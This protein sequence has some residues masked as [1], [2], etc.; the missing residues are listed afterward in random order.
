MNSHGNTVL[1]Q[2]PI[3]SYREKRGSKAGTVTMSGAHAAG[4]TSLTV[5][6]GTGTFSR[7]DWIQIARS[8]T[9]PIAHVVTATEVAGVVPIYP[10]LRIAKS[11]GDTVRHLGDGTI[12]DTMELA[13]D[14]E[15]AMS[16]PSPAP[17]FFQPFALEFVTALRTNI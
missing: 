10:G 6:G 7:G 15:F 17:G 8:A 1:F 9:H 11:N 14:P 3:F 13:G 16:M 2:I 4:A 5:T 12:H